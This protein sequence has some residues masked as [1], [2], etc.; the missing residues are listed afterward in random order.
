MIYVNQR[1]LKNRDRHYFWKHGESVSSLLIG[2]QLCE[3]AAGL[4]LC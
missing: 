1:K 2:F 4:K 3:S